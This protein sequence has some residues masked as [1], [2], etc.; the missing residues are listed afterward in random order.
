MVFSTASSGAVI[1]DRFS[2][3]NRNIIKPSR[4]LLKSKGAEA[5]A[6]RNCF[7][8]AFALPPCRRVFIATQSRTFQPSGEPSGVPSGV[9]SGAALLRMPVGDERNDAGQHGE[10]EARQTDAGR[11]CAERGDCGDDQ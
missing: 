7:L 6:V 1:G 10:A 4:M 8:S 2:F 11:T 3:C 9:R 5:R